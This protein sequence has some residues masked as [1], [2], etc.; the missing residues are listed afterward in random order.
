VTR[1]E[2]TLTVGRA[3]ATPRLRLTL[4]LR[5]SRVPLERLA[6]VALTMSV[7]VPDTVTL[8]LTRGGRRIG[9]ARRFVDTDG[10]SVPLRLLLRDGVR[11]G[12]YELTGVYRGT[13]TVLRFVV[14]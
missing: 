14:V 1:G 3:A 13:R 12:R 7:T 4:G 2:A 5:G 8:I 9:S 10:V 11:R 6:G